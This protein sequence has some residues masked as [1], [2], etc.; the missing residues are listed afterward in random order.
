[1]GVIGLK[2]VEI[3]VF[4]KNLRWLPK[5][6]DGCQNDLLL[7]L[8]FK[9]RASQTLTSLDMAILLKIKHQ[10]LDGLLWSIIM[11][12]CGP[13]LQV[14]TFKIS[15]RLKFQDRA[16]CGNLGYVQSYFH[17]APTSLVS[18]SFYAIALSCGLL[19]CQQLAFTMAKN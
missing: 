11:P 4:P 10:R 8:S 14:R 7:S 1:M 16:K 3:W 6:Q 2:L 15:V 13:I 5:I 17:L 19:L 18:F 9:C 12:L